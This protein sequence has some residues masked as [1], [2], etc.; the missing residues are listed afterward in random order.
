MSVMDDVQTEGCDAD[1]MAET[2]DPQ[3]TDNVLARQV[4]LWKRERDRLDDL[5][6]FAS[7]AEKTVIF[8]NLVKMAAREAMGDRPPFAGPVLLVLEISLA[9]PASWSRKRQAMAESGQIC[10][11]KK[12]DADNV[13][14]AVKDGMNGIVWVDDCQAVDYRI[15]KRYS[16]SPGV[17]V[18]VV[19]LP[20]ERA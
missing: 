17:Y 2:A 10:A 15:S 9:I 6:T 12:P 5:I 7:R 16:A 4:G 3:S 20:L 18:E 13:L 19:E 1:A 11:T 8:E 14:K